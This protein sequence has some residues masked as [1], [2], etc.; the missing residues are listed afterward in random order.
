MKTIDG[1]SLSVEALE[2]RRRTIIRMKE[3]GCK[4]TEI[5][6]ATGCSRQSIHVLWVKWIKSKSQNKESSILAVKTRGNK[7]GEGRTLEKK[8]E[9]EI[10]RIIKNKYPDQLEF[11]FALWTREAVVK[12]IFKMYKIKMPIRTVGEYLKRWGYTPQ[13]PL[14]YA[15]ERDPKKVKEW[16]ET[17]YPAI[18]M[19]AKRQ[20]ADIY[21]GDETTVKAND[22]RGRGYAPKGK[23]PIV[24]RTEKK[25][26]VSMVSAI[27]N[28]GKVCWKLH[29]GSINAI[30][31]FDF[32]KRLVKSSKRKVFLI[33]DNARTHHSKI[34]TEWVEKNKG[35]IAV[36]YIPP[37]SPDLNPD[38]HINAD[39]KYGVGSKQPK[40]TKE[41]LR[42]TTQSHM[43]MLKRK[44]NR[45]IKYF[46][47]PA[48]E[49]AK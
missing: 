2:E 18:K 17:T 30:K 45:I 14:K 23:T 39:V 26:N 32:V 9:T 27:T 31:F 4:I 37:Y 3:A 40:R 36:F 35:K 19:R 44:P 11:D 21:W 8:Q 42:K 7:Y 48:I 38:E 1:R 5:V 20:K 47:D 34:L 6:V 33:I 10:K 12:L 16:L 13:K 24:N 43:L 28:K 41:E 25:E 22:V 46:C 29:E 49:H 15:Y